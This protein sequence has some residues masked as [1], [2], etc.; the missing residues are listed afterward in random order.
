ML[1]YVAVVQAHDIICGFGS[2]PC[3]C[4]WLLALCLYMWFRSI[5]LSVDVVQAF[6]TV[7]GYC[8]D[9]AKRNSQREQNETHIQEKTQINYS[10]TIFVHVTHAHKFTYKIV[11][12]DNAIIIKRSLM[13]I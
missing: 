11:T 5:L 12:C 6:A 2:G 10:Y 8:Q 1:L 9:P 4:M 7:V 3:Y 13:S